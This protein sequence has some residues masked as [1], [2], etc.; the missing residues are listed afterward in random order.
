M[1]F[2]V[3]VNN[4]IPV[5]ALFGEEAQAG[6]LHALAEQG[7]KNAIASLGEGP[8]V[9]APGEPPNTQSG[10]LEGSIASDAN[11][12]IAGSDHSGYLELGTRKMAARPFLLKA[13]V[14]VQHDVERI[15]HETLGL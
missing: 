10:D 15:A 6:F 11:L 12:T 5:A 7:A 2:R 4:C 9:S 3:L 14:D 13:C 1:P 8:E